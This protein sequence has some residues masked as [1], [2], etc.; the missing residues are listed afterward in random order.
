[1]PSTPV[2]AFV[3]ELR[4]RT[5]E[6]L[7]R[8]LAGRPDLAAA[9]PTDLE[10][11]A[12]LASARPS[13]H[14]AVQGLD[15]AQ[16]DLLERAVLLGAHTLGEHRPHNDGA[17][18]SGLATLHTLGLIHRSS[19]GSSPD[20]P[21]SVPDLPD[22]PDT[23]VQW[24][25][26]PGV[27]EALGRYPAGIGRPLETLRA[28]RTAPDAPA[29]DR[30]PDPLDL[31]ALP[32]R[33]AEV[34]AGFRERPL[35]SIRDAWRDPVPDDP[36][37]RPID[38]LL[39]REML[40]PL[41]PRHVEVPRE[42]GLALHRGDPWSEHG[43]TPPKPTGQPVRAAVRDN[44]ALAAV[45]D[46]IGDLSALR[47]ELR[48]RPLEV[49][50]AGGIGVRERRRLTSALELDPAR[51]DRLLGYAQLSGLIE[52]ED[53]TGAWRPT[54][55][56]WESLD[57]ATA[58]GVLV[59]AWLDSASIASAVGEHRADGSVIIPLTEHISRPEA[60]ALRRA[61]LAAS[62]H[63]GQTAPDR[64]SFT[65]ILS[66][67][68]PRLAG[69]LAHVGWPLFQECADLGLTGAGAATDVIP[70]LLDDGAPA[71]THA[72]RDRLPP[73]IHR[74][75]IQSDYTAVAH[76]TLS[77]DAAADLAL[78]ADL[79]SRGAAAT[80]RF[81]TSSLHRALEAGHDQDSLR[82]LLRTRS[83][84]ELP[85]ALEH[86]VDEAVRTHGNLR[87]LNAEQVVTGR[88][89]LVEA[90]AG[91]TALSGFDAVRVSPE[92]LVLKRRGSDRAPGL[93]RDPLKAAVL[94]A[95]EQAGIQP[96]VDAPRPLA[97]Q[98]HLTGTPEELLTLFPIP[99]PAQPRTDP[100]HI[101][102]VAQRLAGSA[103]TPGQEER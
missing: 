70:L 1:M 77:P 96:G 75:I 29:R 60:P 11:L 14:S 47:S 62:V 65:E 20:A 84:A 33:P 37:S 6:Q 32:P 42:V 8:M 58:H 83:E 72:L 31:S 93:R 34:L 67:L 99:T 15:R 95:A 71:V 44:A 19:A 27:S 40:L 38:W 28:L 66:W 87:V 30:L 26:S 80:Y 5:G 81:S 53:R 101:R 51:T 92:I 41:D 3:A 88:S 97:H 49:L 25:L 59:A 91:S 52:Q 89:D 23:D 24:A 9:T 22:L 46:V 85:Q 90:I 64:G 13:L 61:V 103:G 100:E 4:T 82:L 16:L 94:R 48:D 74:V 76:G 98:P 43:H 73:P 2:A 18:T 54:Q 50:R 78:V 7:Q 68:R 36:D 39:A 10:E 21:R 63:C 55:A 69:A 45:A 57:V 102:I 79:E 56:P 17:P 35:G 12:R 86:L